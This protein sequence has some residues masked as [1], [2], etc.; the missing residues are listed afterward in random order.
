MVFSDYMNSLSNEA[1]SEKRK[2]IKELADACC[3]S[4]LTV[5]AWISG[6]QEPDALNKKII[7][8]VL[9]MPVDELFPPKA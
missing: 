7:S 2:K 9:G 3:K 6:R 4:D 1:I 5:Y 8:G